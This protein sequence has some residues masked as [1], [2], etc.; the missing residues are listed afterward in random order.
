LVKQS[1][2]D[3]KIPND[4]KIYQMAIKLYSKIVFQN[5]IPNNIPNDHKMY[6]NLSFQGPSKYTNTHEL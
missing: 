4:R 3:E 6:Q 2:N 5:N 1:K